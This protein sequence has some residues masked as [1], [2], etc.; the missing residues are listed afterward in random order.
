MGIQ[1]FYDVIILVL[2]AIGCTLLLP[3]YFT[4]MFTN[5]ISYTEDKTAL[6]VQNSLYMYED[7]KTG[8]DLM[9]S[10]VVVDDNVAFPRSIR[11]NNTPIIDLNNA[12]I[13]NKYTNIV[14]VYETGGQWKLG[15][16][17]N[18]KIQEVKY[19]YNSGDPYLHYIL[20]P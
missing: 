20:S 10:L 9:M 4:V 3:L 17:L 2:V 5:P 6:D 14:K 11:I 16:M 19:E 15:N 7:I 13:I 18:W 1:K 12:W 8:K